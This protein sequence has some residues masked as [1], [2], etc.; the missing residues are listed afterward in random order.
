MLQIEDIES[1]SVQVSQ[2]ALPSGI[3]FFKLSTEDVI[4]KTGKIIV[5]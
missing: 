1:S 5:E 4:F 2:P 3:Y